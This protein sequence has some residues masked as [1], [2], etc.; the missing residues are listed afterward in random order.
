MRKLDPILASQDYITFK[1]YTLEST[2]INTSLTFNQLALPGNRI[3]FGMERNIQSCPITNF[4]I[5]NRTNLRSNRRENA[6]D[7]DAI[8]LDVNPGT[9]Q[10]TIKTFQIEEHLFL[11]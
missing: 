2:V 3:V 8:L 7:I 9:N 6:I 1:Q 5:C 4:A 11:E 10:T